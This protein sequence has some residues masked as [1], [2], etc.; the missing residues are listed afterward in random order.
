MHGNTVMLGNGSGK[1]T[2]HFEAILSELGE[3]WEIHRSLGGR[4]GGVHIEV[5]DEDVTECV[6][7]A[8]GVR[9]S[10]LD[11]RYTTACD[12]RLNYD[13]AMELAFMLAECVRGGAGGS[14]GGRTA[15]KSG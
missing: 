14:E 6:G 5:T 11:L 9:E 13:Q 4:L 8:S 10:D 2:R 12:P 15:G 7:G 1:K 3:C